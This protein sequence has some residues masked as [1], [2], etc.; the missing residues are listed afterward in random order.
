MDSPQTVLFCASHR[1]NVSSCCLPLPCGTFPSALASLYNLGIRQFPT[2]LVQSSSPLVPHP[3]SDPRRLSD[4]RVIPCSSIPVG[5]ADSWPERTTK[6][7]SSHTLVSSLL[8]RDTNDS[9]SIGVDVEDDEV[10]IRPNVYHNEET[11]LKDEK[12]PDRPDGVDVVEIAK[13]TEED[14]DVIEQSVQLLMDKG[15]IYNTI[16]DAK[17]KGPKREADEHANSLADE[18][19]A[20]WLADEKDANVW[21]YFSF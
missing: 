12:Q 10:T 6:R 18:E 20:K 8:G 17:K 16:D 13:T 4:Q 1:L 9:E 15:L 5:P 21:S 3:T 19:D 7:S 2:Y 11:G 14:A